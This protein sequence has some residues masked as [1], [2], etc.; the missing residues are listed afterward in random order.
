MPEKNQRVCF[1]HK[2]WQI[3]SSLQQFEHRRR[4]MA[5][6]RILFKKLIGA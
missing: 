4:R 2:T 3:G 6:N 5:P 1:M